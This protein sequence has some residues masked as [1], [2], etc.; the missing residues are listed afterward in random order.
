MQCEYFGVCGSCDLGGN[1]YEDQL[2]IKVQTQ[3]ERFGD[4]YNGPFD[5][6]TSQSD[7]FRDRAEFRIFRLFDKF[8]NPTIHYAMNSVEKKPFVINTCSIVNPFIADLMPKLLEAISQDDDLSTKLFG[9]EFL[10]STSNDMLVTLLYHRKLQ[11]NWEEKAK[12]LQDK[13]NIKI[14]GRSRKQ[15][16][17]LKEDF[18]TQTL[19]INDRTY[20]FEYFEGGFT[21]P[22]QKVNQQMISWV[23]NNIDKQNDLCELY[24]GGG[25]F[26][27]PLSSCFEKVLATEISKTSIKS[28]LKNCQLNGV[29][30]IT[31]IRMSSEEFVEARN[32]IREFTRLKQQNVNLDDYNFSTIFVDPPRAGLDATTTKLCSEFEQIIYISCNPETLHRDLQ[33]LTKTHDI[34]KFAFFDQ[35]AYSSHIESGVI[36]NKKNPKTI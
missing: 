15:K 11:T 9:V 36:L 20:L 30:N 23:I 21:Q 8:N 3:K 10:C 17:I 2:N 32:K 1:S 18:I 13:F 26:T 34:Q 7:A 14:I 31:F 6:I 19:Q 28:A 29:G 27:L 5:I 25:N 33:E 16:I 12:E 4:I 22:N 35:F 24:C